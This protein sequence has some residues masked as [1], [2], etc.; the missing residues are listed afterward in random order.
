MVIRRVT[1]VKA[2]A[3]LNLVIRRCNAST[4]TQVYAFLAIG[5]RF[6]FFFTIRRLTFILTGPLIIATIDSH[7]LLHIHVHLT[8][9]LILQ[10]GKIGPLLLYRV[11]VRLGHGRR[12]DTAKFS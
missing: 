9:P 3:V 1:W 7:V 10:V 2:H 11:A 4:C 6:S 8:Q 5:S 12:R